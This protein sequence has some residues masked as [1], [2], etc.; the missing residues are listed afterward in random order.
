MMLCYSRQ[1]QE[2]QPEIAAFRIDDFQYSD[3]RI[4]LGGVSPAVY[5]DVPICVVPGCFH[6]RHISHGLP[7]C[8]FYPGIGP[9]GVISTLDNILIR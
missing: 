1:A 7:N 5:A 3:L 6:G 9:A 8:F 4:Q 2:Q